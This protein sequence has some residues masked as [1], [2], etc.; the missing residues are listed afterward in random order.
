[1]LSITF[2]GG[3][4]EIDALFVSGMVHETRIRSENMVH[5]D[6]AS[7]ILAEA[8]NE[9]LHIELSVEGQ[10]GGDGG[11]IDIT[12]DTA[13]QMI[14]GSERDKRSLQERDNNSLVVQGGYGGN[15]YFGGGNGGD[16]SA[17]GEDGVNPGDDG[18]HVYAFGGSGGIAFYFGDGGSGG[19]AFAVGGNGA[20][21]ADP[22]G[23]G[24]DGGDAYAKGGKRGYNNRTCEVGKEAGSARARGG[25]GGLGGNGCAGIKS[26][27]GGDGGR[28]GSAE[29]VSTPNGLS[30]PAWAYGGN[31]GDGGPGTNQSGY[32][33]SGGLAE[34]G[35]M[36]VVAS[37][38]V[39]G[40]DG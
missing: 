4:L 39:D 22:N 25:Q 15:G 8:G 31:G 23:D 29:A 6:N 33:G 5:E 16:A 2:P 36:E 38:E 35:T 1:M 10:I 11:D 37:R 20:D 14:Q 26:D 34:I 17:I 30:T 32:G 7:L 12:V 24:G 28:G 21:G 27:R 19:Y 18:R 3:M 40:E 13:A 9:Y